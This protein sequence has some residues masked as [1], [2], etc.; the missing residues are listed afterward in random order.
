MLQEVSFV[1]GPVLAGGVIALWSPTAAVAASAVLALAGA[2]MFAVSRGARRAG[3]APGADAEGPLA[4]VAG[5][6]MRTVLASAAGFGLAFGV[7]DV[8]FPAFARVHGS[9]ATAGVLLSALAAGIGVGS[10]GY[11]LRRSRTPASRAYPLLCLLAAAGLAPLVSMPPLGAMAALAFVAGLCF[12]PVTASQIAI[13]DDV[14]PAGRR[15]EALTW[16]GTLYGAASAA[17]A[18]LAGQLV[19]RGST[20][21]AFAGACGA[22]LAAWAVAAAR[23]GTLAAAGTAEDLTARTPPPATPG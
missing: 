12:A 14:A 16:I 18:A 17:G 20:R 11:G 2:V 6:G 15:A 10:F 8:A 4:A 19:T 13:L 9:A 23:A 21:V 3:E 22:A 5:A 7:L 1:T